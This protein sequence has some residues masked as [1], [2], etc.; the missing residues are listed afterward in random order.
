MISLECCMAIMG[1]H[2]IGRVK[3]L[4]YYIQS[5]ADLSFEAQKRHTGMSHDRESGT[6]I[7]Q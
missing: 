1:E 3:Y 6:T 5:N 4:N 7:F 2:N